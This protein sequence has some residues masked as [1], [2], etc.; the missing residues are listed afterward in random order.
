MHDLVTNRYSEALFALA[1]SRG[2]LGDVSNDIARIGQEMASPAVASFVVDAR[3]PQ[4]TRREKFGL[5]SAD[6]NEITRNFVGLLFEKRREDVLPGI[7]EAFRARLLEE[8][9]AA[10]GYVESA[11]P[12]DA[13]QVESLAA[14]I[15]LKIDRRVTLENRVRPELMGGVRVLV[16]SRMLD[17]S[18]QG[19]LDGLR[20]SMLQAVMPSGTSSSGSAS[21]DA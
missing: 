2:A 18:V 11:R 12:L 4:A 3:I 14:A 17:M 6:F 9:G 15:G 13:A 16:G 8:D 7:A 5:V 1:K 19:R 10:E 21:A 20:E